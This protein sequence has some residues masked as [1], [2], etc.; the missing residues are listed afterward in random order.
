MAMVIQERC[1]QRSLN[2]ILK[3]KDLFPTLEGSNS[4]DK[5]KLLH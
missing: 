3:R 4:K 2:W 5:K 1:F